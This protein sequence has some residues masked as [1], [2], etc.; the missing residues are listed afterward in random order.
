MRYKDQRPSAARAFLDG[1][2]RRVQAGGLRPLQRVAK[3]IFTHVEGL[4]D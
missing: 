3:M 2:R 1:W 4:L